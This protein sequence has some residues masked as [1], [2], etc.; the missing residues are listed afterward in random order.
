MRRKML[1]ALAV[2]AGAY[3]AVRFLLDVSVQGVVGFTGDGVLREQERA[4]AAAAQHG[5]DAIVN[6]AV[7][8]VERL[9]VAPATVAQASSMELALADKVWQHYS[10]EP[11]GLGKVLSDARCTGEINFR[12]NLLNPMDLYLEPAVRD[13]FLEDIKIAVARLDRLTEIKMSIAKE[14]VLDWAARGF[15]VRVGGDSAVWRYGER[16]AANNDNGWHT[17][18]L[19]SGEQY[20][21]QWADLTWAEQV[22]ATSQFLEEQFNSSIIDF[23]AQHGALDSERRDAIHMY[24]INGG[25]VRLRELASTDPAQYRYLQRL[26]FGK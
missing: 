9:G 19:A 15:F 26:L 23:F 18:I 22:V 10:R 3:C 8:A 12:S 2:A 7:T 17:V 24:W 14:Q 16:T 4:T 13:R 20:Q 5:A 25:D 11:M 1:I 6:E 21:I